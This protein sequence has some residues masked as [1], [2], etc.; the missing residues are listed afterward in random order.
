MIAFLHPNSIRRKP[1]SAAK[2]KP[3]ANGAATTNGT[4]KGKAARARKGGRPS[5]P[6]KKTADELDAEMNDYF[7]DGGANAA[8]AAAQNGAADTGMVD[9]VL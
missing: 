8:P 6:K 7:G 3:K 4:A 5:K 2:E 9:E 1:K